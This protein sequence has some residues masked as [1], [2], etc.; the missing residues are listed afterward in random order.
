MTILRLCTC[1]DQ[2]Y[3]PLFSRTRQRLVSPLKWYL[4]RSIPEAS[5]T[6]MNI[7][8]TGTSADIVQSRCALKAARSTQKAPEVIKSECGW[9]VDRIEPPITF[10]LTCTIAGQKNSDTWGRKSSKDQGGECA[11]RPW[12]LLKPKFHE[13]YGALSCCVWHFA[14]CDCPALAVG[15][16]IVAHLLIKA[17]STSIE[18]TQ[19]HPWKM[20]IWLNCSKCSARLNPK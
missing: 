16:R 5:R 9:S 1:R 6:L 3:G 19:Y 7:A 11:C 13:I 15:C 10:Q 12:C 18:S 20:E 4:G 8:H 2:K 14:L 17:T